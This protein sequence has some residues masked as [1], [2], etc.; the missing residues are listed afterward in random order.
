MLNTTVTNRNPNKIKTIGFGG[1]KSEEKIIALNILRMEGASVHGK[2][3]GKAKVVEIDPGKPIPAHLLSPNVLILGHPVG[4]YD[5]LATL[6]G[7]SL[8]Q[9]IAKKLHIDELPH[10]ECI[11]DDF[12]HG[13]K[14]TEILAS[15]IARLF[16]SYKNSTAKQR[17]YGVIEDS[18][19]R[20]KFMIKNFEL[21]KETFNQET[22]EEEFQRGGKRVKIALIRTFH[23]NLFLQAI[24]H[25]L[26]DRDV[27]MNW[28][29]S[30]SNSNNPTELEANDNYNRRDVTISL[31]EENSVLLEYLFDQLEKRES[32]KSV[33]GD[34]SIWQKISNKVIVTRASRKPHLNRE[35]ITSCI[36]TAYEIYYGPEISFES[37]ERTAAEK[38]SVACI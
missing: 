38:M 3:I 13:D 26:H 37:A 35:E 27:L 8:A 10:Y 34:S 1:I 7:G 16:K 4:P 25:K 5:A 15:Y 28:H 21:A 19:I 23:R 12:N 33:P 18:A 22:R 30:S 24:A 20:I 36:R 11:L 29:N 6:N 31:K 14:D 2:K 17:F 32:R 9:T